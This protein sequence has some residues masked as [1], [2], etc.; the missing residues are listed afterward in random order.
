MDCKSVGER[1]KARKRALGL[2]ANDLSLRANVPEDTINNI[3]YGRT[4]DPRVESL[5]RIAKAL[6]ISLD[7]LVFGDPQNTPT[8]AS[9]REDQK[10]KF[11]I[12]DYVQSLKEN[13]SREIASLIA[14]HDRHIQDMKD[15]NAREVQA[16]R[17]HCNEV[18]RTHNFWRA[19]SCGLIAVIMGI[20]TLIKVG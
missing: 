7:H 11:N 20:L 2:T 10:P 19:L 8:D 14:S 1:V 17:E 13:H 5:M 12:D 3:I 15:A 4:T 6:D 16:V 9:P 18:R